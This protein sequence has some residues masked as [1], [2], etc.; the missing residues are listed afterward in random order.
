[1]SPRQLALAALGFAAL[2]LLWGAAALRRGREMRGGQAPAVLPVIASQAVDTVAIVRPSDTT[3]LMRRDTASWTVNGH[4]ADRGAVAALLDALADSARRSEPVAERAASHAGLGVDD[5][6]GRRV[7]V[8][9]RSG[10]IADLVVGH[11]TPDLQGGY[12]RRSG[13]SLV[14]L[15]RGPLMEALDRQPDEWR[16]RRIA[17]VTPDSVAVIELRRGRRAVTLARDGTGWT[18]GRGRAA[19]T[20]GVRGL[21]ES[22]RRVEA[23]AFASRAQADSARFNPADRTARLLRADGTPLLALALDSTASGYWVRVDGGPEVSRLESWTADRLVPPDSTL[24]PS[25]R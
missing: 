20:A 24:R 19:D 7:R 3:V 1:M 2:L 16:D 22:Y 4:P 17:A 11:R 12:L 5:G 14:V 18:L 8:A 15:V 13:D 21:L 6:T 23:A 25:S 10:P 9:G